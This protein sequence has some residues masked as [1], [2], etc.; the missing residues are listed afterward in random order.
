MLA[1]MYGSCFISILWEEKKL[2]SKM[3]CKWCRMNFYHHWENQFNSATCNRFVIVLLTKLSLAKKCGG[4]LC[5]RRT[6][7]ETLLSSFTGFGLRQCVVL[8]YYLSLLFFS[9]PQPFLFISSGET[10]QPTSRDNCSG[11]SYLGE[12]RICGE[13]LGQSQDLTFANAL[14]IA[15]QN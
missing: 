6:L 10:Y 7:L 12:D 14:F 5:F 11:A 1:H 15:L 13:R 4:V 8:P 3:A 2:R 9:S